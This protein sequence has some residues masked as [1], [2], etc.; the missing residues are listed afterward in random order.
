MILLAMA[1]KHLISW[2]L[3]MKIKYETKLVVISI[4][5]GYSLHGL[6]DAIMGSGL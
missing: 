6:C 2:G 1:R 4:L 5:L 3:S